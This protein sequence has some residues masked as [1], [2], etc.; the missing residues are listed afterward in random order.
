MVVTSPVPESPFDMLIDALLSHYT[1]DALSKFHTS[2]M[3]GA[4]DLARFSI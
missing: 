2:A 4:N 1:R 3:S